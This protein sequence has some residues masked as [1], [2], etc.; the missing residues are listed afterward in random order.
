MIPRGVEMFIGLEPIDL[1]WGFDRLAG[2]AFA[3]LHPPS[4][5]VVQ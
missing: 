3:P 5:A 1:R 2:V 4:S